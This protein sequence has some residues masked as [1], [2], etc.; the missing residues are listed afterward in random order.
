MD[1]YTQEITARN[2]GEKQAR[3]TYL[4]KEVTILG[5][6]YSCDDG[7]TTHEDLLELIESD[8]YPFHITILID[9]E[10]IIEAGTGV[11]NIIISLTWPFEQ[12]NDELDTEWGE[13]AY[14]YYQEYPDEPSIA[15]KLELRATQIE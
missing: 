9:G 8:R 14:E 7:V 10:G 1:P 2:L 13:L 15:L 4:I 6:T 5:T 11:S 3:V 12:N